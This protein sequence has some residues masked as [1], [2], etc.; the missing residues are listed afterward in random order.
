MRA[1]LL[2]FSIAVL[3]SAVWPCISWS[4]F[5]WFCAPFFPY[6][7]GAFLLLGCWCLYRRRWPFFVRVSL[8][9][10]LGLLW[11]ALWGAWIQGQ[12]LPLEQDKTDYLLVGVVSDVPQ[13][14]PLRTRFVLQ[15]ESL[16]ALDAST[17]TR[18]K[19]LDIHRV[20]LSW[21]GG[22][23]LHPGER[24]QLRVR[25][26]TPRGFANPG[27]FDYAGWLLRRQISATG[28]IRS[29]GV[30][31]KLAQTRQ[32]PIDQFRW[33]VL[34]KIETLNFSAA[35]K[36][37]LAALTIGDKRGL[38]SETW[39]HMRLTGTVHLAVVSGLHIGMVAGLGMLLGNLLGRGLAALGAPVCRQHVAVLLGGGLAL[40]YALLAGFSLS[41][42]RALIMLFVFLLATLLKRKPRP[43]LALLWALALIAASDPLAALSS[44]F[45]LSF[46]A[47]ATF[48]LWFVPRPRGSY[49]RDLCSAQ[50]IIFLPLAGLLS[51]FQGE[52]SGLSPLLNLLAIPWL[53]IAVVPLALFGMLLLPW[54]PDMADGVWTVA[55][56]QLQAFDSVMTWLANYADY[57]VWTL[58]AGQGV[59]LS[60]ALL[61]AGAFMLLPRG[62]GLRSMAM[63]LLLAVALSGQS[64]LHSQGES[65]RGASST[66]DGFTL[67]VLDVG[68]GLSVVVINNGRAVVYDAGPKY[69]ASFNAG[70]GIIAP[71]LRSQGVSSIDVL[72][73]SH[74]DA[75]HTGGTLGL[76]EH[77]SETRI[78]AGQ[79]LELPMSRAVPC[80]A[81][82]NFLGNKD[83]EER[84]KRAGVVFEIVYPWPTEVTVGLKRTSS[85]GS[86]K[87]SDNDSSCVLLI[88]Y[89][90]KT[91]LL[92]GD[93]SVEAEAKLLA[94]G[95]L[96][97]Q[98][99]VLLAPHHGSRT[100]SSQAFVDHLSPT[101]VV[102][103][104]GFNHHFG[105]PAKTV[106]ARFSAIGSRAW[107]TGESGAIIFKWDGTGQLSVHPWRQ[108]ARRYWR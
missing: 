15:V 73:L 66:E 56:W 12:Q 9:F 38:D 41:T 71:Y 78:L 107:A 29:Q 5:S 40:I 39:M 51:F 60:L 49:W 2:A 96:P 61:L 68:Q 93:I 30:N 74:G 33:A 47:V 75:D 79:P 46:V 28:Y 105:H 13:V 67:T 95:V 23:P 42:Q 20:L 65:E 90:G 14:S 22:E 76:L 24:W 89:R 8:A 10:A 83:A 18:G 3:C 99:D 58:P 98:I 94:R 37:L 26:R 85:Q 44:G 81:G 63:V 34:Q 92:P 17:S 104:A 84:W 19:R 106:A 55:A 72:M 82:Q 27:G 35:S 100:S 25:L 101:H 108:E 91:I 57:F 21:Y 54:S 87:I 7:L 102:Y 45:W 88:R 43:E 48:L 59:L 6:L 53:G 64:F 80:L 62:L 86:N 69:S 4:D 52:I 32:Y 70:S 11:A 36:G 16:Q 77:F 50:L 103:A 97:K 1:Y 31:K